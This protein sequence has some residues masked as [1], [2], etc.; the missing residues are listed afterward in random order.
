RSYLAQLRLY[1]L[2][3]LHAC[4]RHALGD[5]RRDIALSL[6]RTPAADGRWEQQR[7]I[8][9]DEFGL[10]DLRS[11]LRLLPPLEEAFARDVEASRAKDDVRGA[12]V[13]DDYAEIHA[14][15]AAEALVRQAWDEARRVQAEVE[16]S[17][18]VLE[19]DAAPPGLSGWDPSVRAV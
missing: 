10:T 17:L 7:Q 13:I 3:G 9:V 8:L 19:A 16:H 15:A 14:P 4:V 18:A 2:R 6:L 5:G 1:A 12:R 11:A